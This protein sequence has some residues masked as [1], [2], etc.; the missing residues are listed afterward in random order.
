ML[1]FTDLITKAAYTHYK[2]GHAL[3]SWEV[4]FILQDTATDRN[5]FATRETQALQI[6]HSYYDTPEK[7]K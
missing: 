6:L 1:S 7:L 2:A 5:I 3:A 4:D